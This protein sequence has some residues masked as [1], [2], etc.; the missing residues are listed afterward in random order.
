MKIEVN[1]ATVN[2]LP[3]D[4]E[5]KQVANGS[6]NGFQGA[7]EDRTTL[8][9]DSL[10]VQS[11][12]SQALTTPAVRQDKVEALRQSINSG[13]Y[14]VDPTKIADAIIGNGE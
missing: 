7:T 10:S 3:V 1:S 2:Q 9:T 12:T 8:R 11:L 13:S 5:P 14:Q 6:V 4:R